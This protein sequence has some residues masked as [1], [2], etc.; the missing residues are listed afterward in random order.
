MSRRPPRA[1]GRRPAWRW[2]A[3]AEGGLSVSGQRVMRAV[4]DAVLEGSLPLAPSGRRPVQLEDEPAV[5]DVVRALQA[6]APVRIRQARTS[7]TEKSAPLKSKGQSR[8]T[9]PLGFNLLRPPLPPPLRG[10]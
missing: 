5:T 4:A 7:V 6:D 8:S 3:G 1:T 2:P 10:L 9:A